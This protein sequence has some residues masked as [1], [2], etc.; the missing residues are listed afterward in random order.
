MLVKDGSCKIHHYKL[1]LLAVEMYKVKNNLSPEFMQD[2]FPERNIERYN[3]RK[4][5]NFQI[6][7]PKTYGTESIQFLGSKIW[8]LIPND[9][10]SATNLSIFKA[11]IK[12][13]AEEA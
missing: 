9:L 5:I 6:P 11:N 8:N 10:K 12:Q 3:L 1:Q 7:G 2:I 4:Q 13:K